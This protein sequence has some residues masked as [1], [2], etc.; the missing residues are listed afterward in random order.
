VAEA[1][2]VEIAA[3]ERSQRL[4]VKLMSTLPA[5]VAAVPVG[6]PGVEW[7]G[8][9]AWCTLKNAGRGEGTGEPS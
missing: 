6:L 2:E 4:S 9:P 7:V 3:G 5:G 8:L 1:A